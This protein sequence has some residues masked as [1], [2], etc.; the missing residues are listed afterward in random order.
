MT[1][2]RRPTKPSKTA[3]AKPAS[4]APATPQAKPKPKPAEARKKSADRTP[5]A[6]TL[7]PQTRRVA[8]EP[9]VLPRERDVPEGRE[10]ARGP[11]RAKSDALLLDDPEESVDTDTDADSNDEPDTADTGPSLFFFFLLFFPSSF[12]PWVVDSAGSVLLPLS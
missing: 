4:K 8:L 10:K 12:L 6:S 1:P 9:E 11:T 3:N 7:E 5:L 2:T